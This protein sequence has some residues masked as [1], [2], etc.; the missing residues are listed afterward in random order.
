MAKQLDGLAWGLVLVVSFAGGAIGGRT[1][2]IPLA[3]AQAPTPFPTSVPARPVPPP[4]P[5]P[6]PTVP[7]TTITLPRGGVVFKTPDGRVVA[8]LYADD[9]GAHLDLYDANRR[10]E[11]RLAAGTTGGHVIILDTSTR[12][13]GPIKSGLTLLD[14]NNQARAQLSVT[15]GTGGAGAL[16]LWDFASDAG[17][18]LLP[19]S[20]CQVIHQF[21]ATGE[22][23]VR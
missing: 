13:S 14:E 5:I 7:T 16:T 15:N 2:S 12:T 17:W 1:F 6:D 10:A 9:Q 8:G 22:S 19:H 20:I 3:D 23:C 11:V 21:R 4:L 18:E